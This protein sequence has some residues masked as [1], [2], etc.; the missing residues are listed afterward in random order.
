MIYIY[1]QAY[2]NATRND[3][4]RVLDVP[5]IPET[6]RHRWFSRRKTRL[7]DPKNL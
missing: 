3:H 2:L 5:S 1:A 4:I 7:I 6:K